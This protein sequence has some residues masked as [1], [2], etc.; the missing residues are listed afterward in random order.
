M[1]INQVHEFNITN[2]SN[3]ANASAANTTIDVE[4]KYSTAAQPGVVQTATRSAN[5]IT[6]VW[7]PMA[8]DPA[9]REILKQHVMEL[10]RIRALVVAG[11]ASY[12][13]F[14]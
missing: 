14:A 2:Y 13:D 3:V 1:A 12:E 7:N 4:L 8:A 10:A 9:G 11:A 5:F 6:Q